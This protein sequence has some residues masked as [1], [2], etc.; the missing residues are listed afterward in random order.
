MI[1][2]GSRWLNMI[3]RDDA[4]Q[5]IGAALERGVNGRIYLGTDDEPVR[6]RDFYAWFA[7]RLG[8]GLPGEAPPEEV[9][10][11][12]RG[13][14]SKRLV[15]RRLREELRVALR[16]PTFREGYAAE[17]AVNRASA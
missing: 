16:F 15:N 5:A 8:R 14:T 9:A 13:L 7:A 4:A 17:L 3:H 12:R 1:G 6:E 2:D 11:R 10:R